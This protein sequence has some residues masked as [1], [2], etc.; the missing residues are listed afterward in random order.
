MVRYRTGYIW[1]Y[2]WITVFFYDVQASEIVPQIRINGQERKGCRLSQLDCRISLVPLARY[3]SSYY[4]RQ[5]VF[6]GEYIFA[7]VVTEKDPFEKRI[8]KSDRK[9]RLYGMISL[10]NYLSSFT[11]DEGGKRIYVAAG[12][13][14]YVYDFDCRLLF[15]VELKCS[16]VTS[17]FF[18][19]DRLFYREF[20]RQKSGEI[21]TLSY[22]LKSREG[23]LQGEKVYCRKLSSENANVPYYFSAS[24]KLYVAFREENTICEL[25]DD[26][27]REVY[28][29]DITRYDLQP[30]WQSLAPVQGIFGQYL[31]Y[32]YGQRCV[33]MQREGPVVFHFDY[34]AGEK[35]IEDDVY[36][37]G[38]LPL[39]RYSNVP[40]RLYFVREGAAF[41]DS[42]S[43]KGADYFLVIMD[44]TG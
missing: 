13:C 41:P 15:S 3:D 25:K 39:M 38:F 8:L 37:T 1:W 19:N 16:G 42:Y 31:I 11:C 12:N 33:I 40:G 21:Y 2:V 5:V 26:R 44:F 35:G 43:E 4:Y 29:F 10:E 28:R 7:S 14:I 6:A 30:F 34:I 32:C 27:L 9:N 20:Y 18:H 36:G 23:N 22:A 24:G 17:L